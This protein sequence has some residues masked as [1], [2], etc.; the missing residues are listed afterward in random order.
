VKDYAINAIHK[1]NAF[2]VDNI[3]IEYL[4]KINVFAKMDFMN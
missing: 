3:L 4:L 2:L 1:G